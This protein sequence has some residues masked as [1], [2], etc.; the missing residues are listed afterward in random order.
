[1][2]DSFLNPFR[3]I[4][5][6]PLFRNGVEMCFKCDLFPVIDNFKSM[7]FSNGINESSF[8]KNIKSLQTNNS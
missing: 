1:M 8:M 5:C 7:S 2:I 3:I 6:R 4:I